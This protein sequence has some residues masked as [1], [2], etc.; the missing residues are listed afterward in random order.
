MSR[1]IRIIRYLFNWCW[2]C[3][4]WI[5]IWIPWINQFTLI[6]STFFFFVRIRFSFPL[7]HL[8]LP[9][10]HLKRSQSHFNY[11]SHDL[12]III[13]TITSKKQLKS[14]KTNTRPE[15]DQNWYHPRDSCSYSVEQEEVL[16]R[17]KVSLKN[18]QFYLIGNSFWT[19]QTC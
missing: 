16:K 19:R 5:E 8:H 15:T 18:V 12:F 2:E 4:I 14:Q 17:K 13:L 11:N 1:F 9:K 7:Y 3:T 10:S 6:G